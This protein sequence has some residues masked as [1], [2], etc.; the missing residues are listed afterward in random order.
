MTVLEI[1]KRMPFMSFNWSEHNARTAR[2][3]YEER[4]V[5]DAIRCELWSVAPP[6][7][8]LATLKARL[9]LA[10]GSKEDLAVD[11]LVTLGLLTLHE[12]QHVS[13]PVQAFEFVQAVERGKTNAENG[14][15]G[16]RPPLK[17]TAGRKDGEF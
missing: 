13:D 17:S 2:L 9:R 6:R 8:P 3:T 10:A 14:R 7:M 16:G 12:D 15:K 4:G 1:N 11:E 5:F